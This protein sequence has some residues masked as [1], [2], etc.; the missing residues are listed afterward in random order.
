MLRSLNVPF[1]TRRTVRLGVRSTPIAAV[2]IVLAAHFVLHSLPADLAT[3][4]DADQFVFAQRLALGYH[5]Q[6]PIYS[7]LV[8]ATFQLAGP[9]LIAYA[10]MKT[11]GIRANVHHSGRC[12][13]S[14]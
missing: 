2:A 14:V 11:T 12:V 4:D 13:R 6:P 8:W 9:S 1:A 7:W 5:E 3:R 10:A